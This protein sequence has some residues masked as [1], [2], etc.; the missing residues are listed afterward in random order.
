MKICGVTI[1]FVTIF[2][3]SRK[4]CVFFIKLDIVKKL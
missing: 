2:H 1:K 3:R 4:F